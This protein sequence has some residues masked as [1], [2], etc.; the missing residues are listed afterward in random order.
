M[1]RDR[2]TCRS[3]AIF[4]GGRGLYLLSALVLHRSFKYGYPIKLIVWA[5]LAAPI[6]IYEVVVRGML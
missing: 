4:K 6:V 3:D 5:I 1:L 2:M